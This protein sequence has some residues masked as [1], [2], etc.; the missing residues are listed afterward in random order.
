MGDEEARGEKL[1]GD[2]KVNWG[3][4]EVKEKPMGDEEAQEKTH[5]R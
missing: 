2:E 5:G 4:K 1:M 3:D